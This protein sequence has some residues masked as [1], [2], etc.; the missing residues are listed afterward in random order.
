MTN[1]LLELLAIARWGELDFLVIDM[2]PGIGDATLD[3]VRLVKKAQFLVITTPSALVLQTV[4]KTVAVLSILRV[5]L[6]GLI[7]NMKRP[8]SPDIEEQARR[9][10]IPYLGAVWFDQ[11]LEESLG[12]ASALAATAVARDI[13]RIVHGTLAFQACLLPQSS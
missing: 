7:E 11:G 2:P 5:P 1:A 8:E 9:M 3:T 13:E 12:N 10:H 6:I 4:K